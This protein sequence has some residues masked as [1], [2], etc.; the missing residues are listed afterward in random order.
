[1]SSNA[2]FVLIV[3]GCFGI[4]AW[5]VVESHPWFALLIIIIGSSVSF[6]SSKSK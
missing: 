1:M 4:G 6:T 3:L 5:L 2:A